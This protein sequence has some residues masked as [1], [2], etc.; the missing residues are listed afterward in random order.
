[1]PD[2]LPSLRPALLLLIFAAL[3]A[4]TNGFAQSVSVTVDVLPGAPGRLLIQGSGLPRE[5]WSFRDSYAGVLGLGNRVR[6]FQLFDANGKQIAARKIAPGQFT[7]NAPATNFKYEIELAPPARPA[8]AAFISWLTTDRGMLMLGDLLPESMS[9]SPATISARLVM[10][11]GWTAYSSDSGKTVTQIET[12]DPDRSVVVIGKKVRNSTQAIL[13]KPFTLLTDG[14]WAFADNDALELVRNILDLHSKS[15]GQSPCESESL[16]LLPFPQVSAANKWSAQTRGC[17]VTLLMGR[18]PSKVG[19][20]S[21]LEL[22]LTHE[23]F[24]LWVPNGLALTG[25]YDWFYEGFTM[26]QAT[27]AAV[28]LELVSFDQFLAAIADAYDGS[29]GS[30]APQ[31][32]LIEASQQRWSVGASTV[33]SKAMVVAFLY[34]MN[35]RWQTKG[36]QSLDDVYRTIIRNHLAKSPATGPR[37]DGNS[38]VIG[39]LRLEMSEQDFVNRLIVMRATIDLEKELTPFGL[40]VEKPGVRTHI[41]VNAH[42]TSRQRDLLKQLGYNEAR[43]R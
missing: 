23:L 38:A 16:V 3:G 41:S 15:V 21:Q 19:A 24:H 8:D 40:L 12:S 30:D 17:T 2:F 43:R 20:L 25:N 9:G 7:S 14:D 28:R 35:L 36:K 13:G 18:V 37:P 26:Y 27:R 32:S 5:T 42:L 11:S 22:A 39:A 4:L 1:M 31:L 29:S 33:Y 34:D 10:S 6:G